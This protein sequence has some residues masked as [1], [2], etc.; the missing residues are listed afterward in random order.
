MKTLTVI[1]CLIMAGCAKGSEAAP[2]KADASHVAPTPTVVE[3]VEA[4][5]PAPPV[6]KVEL[7]IE[8][9]GNTMTFNKTAMTVPAKSEVHLVFKNNSTMDVLPHNW[10]LVH[11][12]TEAKVAADGL[13]LGPDHNYLPDTDDVIVGTPLTKPGKTNEI[14]FTA[15]KYPGKY[16]YICTIPGHY[17]MMKGVLTVTAAQE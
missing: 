8:S 6:Q 3:V 10:V 11:P 9:V 2:T 1:A 12:G 15:P 14:T 16:P 5:P 13:A 7:E 17:I 4:A